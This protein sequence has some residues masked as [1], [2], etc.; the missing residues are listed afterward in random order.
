MF[1]RLFTMLQVL[2]MGGLLLSGI[3]APAKADTPPQGRQGQEWHFDPEKMQAMITARL[4]KLHERLEIKASQQGAWDAFAKSVEALPQGMAS[5]PDKDADAATIAHFRAERT[6]NIAKKLSAIADTTAKLQAVLTPSQ[7]EIL[8]EQ[9][10]HFG[11]HGFGHR[12][13]SP[14]GA[15]HCDRP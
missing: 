13:F 6:A 11:H 7:R 12:G 10:R 15:W 14:G 5:P 8:N 2:V 1:T 9:S 3:A 4:D